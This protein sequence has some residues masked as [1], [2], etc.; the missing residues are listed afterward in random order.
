MKSYQNWSQWKGGCQ[1]TIRKKEKKG[2]KADVCQISQ[3]VDWN[4]MAVLWR[5]EFEFELFG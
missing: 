2:T 1:D 5:D 3:E 4:S